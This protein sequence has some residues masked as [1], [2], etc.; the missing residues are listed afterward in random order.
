MFLVVFRNRKRPDVDYDA[1]ARDADAMER[2]ARAQP[3][4]LA[5]KSYVADDGEVVAISE[6]A[7]EEAARQWRRNAEHAAVQVR[8]RSEYYQDYTLFAC[9]EPR[10]RRFERPLLEGET[11]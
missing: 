4:F 5:F 10:I 7:G 6:W 2:L 8:G 9:P 1:Y 11:P 3:G